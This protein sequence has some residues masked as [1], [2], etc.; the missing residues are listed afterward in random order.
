MLRIV[1]L[2]FFL[3]CCIRISVQ[4]RA[5]E[6]ELDHESEDVQSEKITTRLDTFLKTYGKCSIK[7]VKPKWADVDPNALLGKKTL[8][9]VEC[10]MTFSSWNEPI[11]VLPPRSILKDMSYAMSRLVSRANHGEDDEDTVDLSFTSPET[12]RFLELSPKARKKFVKETC[13]KFDPSAVLGVSWPKHCSLEVHLD[14]SDES[15]KIPSKAGRTDPSKVAKSSVILEHNANIEFTP[16]D[17]VPSKM[18]YVG[19][20]FDME[21]GEESLIGEDA[22]YPVAPDTSSFRRTPAE[23]DD[24]ETREAIGHANTVLGLIYGLYHGWDHHYSGN[25]DL[26]DVFDHNCCHFAKAA[27]EIL[28]SKESYAQYT[29]AMVFHH[30]DPHHLRQALEEM[31]GKTTARLKAQVV[32]GVSSLFAAHPDFKTLLQQFPN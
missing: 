6:L 10:W 14:E 30:Q 1:A 29:S 31:N 28:L 18:N 13:P 7:E 21:H 20:E 16:V 19:G 24:E 12:G 2:L 11:T 26:Y 15:C 9:E 8:Q 17:D 32:G 25:P 27:M 3:L 22:T 5:Q 23:E 4:S